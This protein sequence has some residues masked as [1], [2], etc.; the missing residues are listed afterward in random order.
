[1]KSYKERTKDILDKRDLY[2]TKKKNQHKIIYATGSVA[3]CA[4]I[5]FGVLGSLGILGTSGLF[6]ITPGA[7]N[8]NSNEAYIAEGNSASA[9]D[10][11]QNS[12]K[13]DTSPVLYSDLALTNSSMTD[14]SDNTKKSLNSSCLDIRGFDE[15]M[16]QNCCAILEGTITNIY[17]KNYS[18]DIYNDHFEKGGI[19]H[20][21]AASIIYELKVNKVLYGNN[22]FT[23]T[24]YLIEDQMFSIDEISILKIGQ[25]Y[26]IPIS[27]EGE[28][29]HRASD[30]ASGDI[31]RDSLYATLYPFHSQIQVTDDGNYMVTW[32][33]PTLIEAGSREIVFD[34]KSNEYPKFQGGGSYMKLVSE[35]NFT[36]QMRKLIELYLK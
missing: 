36:K 19:L 20:N 1:M 11:T 26:V 15:K 21:K 33:W 29:I 27:I 30:Y 2:F 4:V 5:I 3:A 24:T 8:Q 22:G 14:I 12:L 35:P 6:K 32:D 9:N 16:I 28:K 13:V 7:F 18:F 34:D 17:Y 25:K 23:A 31:T 10:V